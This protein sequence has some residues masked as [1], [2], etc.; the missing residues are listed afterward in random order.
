MKVR[1]VGPTELARRLEVRQGTVSAWFTEGAEP[2]A[3]Q[4]AGIPK[5]LEISGHWLLAN[6]GTMD[7]EPEEAQRVLGEIEKLLTA[8]SRDKKR[9]AADAAKR[10][11]GKK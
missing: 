3:G 4:L 1:G 10:A 2:K 5:A 6:E 11:G 8:S 9:G 7:D